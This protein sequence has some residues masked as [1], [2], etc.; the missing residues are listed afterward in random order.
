MYVYCMGS[1]TSVC[2]CVCVYIY[3][4]EKSTIRSAN[5]YKRRL[6]LKVVLPKK[7]ESSH[8]HIVCRVG[9]RPKQPKQGL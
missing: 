1:N 6:S 7:T 8:T 9:L 4:Y 3:I 5:D 2:L